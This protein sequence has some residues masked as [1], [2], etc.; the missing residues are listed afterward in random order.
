MH[1]FLNYIFLVGSGLCHQIPARSLFFNGVQLPLCARCTGIYVGFIVAFLILAF[2]YRS[3]N[4]RGGLSW[5]YYPVG[6]VLILPMIYDGFSSY[7]G[8]RS[9]TNGLR[10]VTGAAFGAAL[11]PIIYALIADALMARGEETEVLGD[12][13][14]RVLYL[15]AVPL[16][17][18]GVH[19][20]GDISVFVLYFLVALSVLSLFTL[21]ALAVVATLPPYY[22]T[23]S[24]VRTALLPCAI[25][26][27]LGVAILFGTWQLQT[28]IHRMIGYSSV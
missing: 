10:L 26:L 22:R 15:C 1:A 19:V 21:T 24:N 14:G 11:A 12:V 5:F 9:T 4:R 20:V 28:E 17:V 13:S 16:T 6:V 27:I 7:L 2:A 3:A 8:F 23:V 25:A 18:M